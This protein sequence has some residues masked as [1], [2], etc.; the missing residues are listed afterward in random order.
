MKKYN[1]VIEVNCSFVNHEKNKLKNGFI[2]VI[3]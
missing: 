2:T 1:N 3:N